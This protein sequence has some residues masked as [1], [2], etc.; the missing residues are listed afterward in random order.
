MTEDTPARPVGAYETFAVNLS[1]AANATIDDAV[2]EGTILND[3]GALPTLSINDIQVVEG[4]AGTTNAV[5]TVTQSAASA[6]TV[7]AGYTTADG[8]AQAAAGTDVY[9]N[10]GTVTIPASG[11][12]GSAGP[13][14]ST[15]T[16]PARTTAV[17]KVTAT[18]SLTHTYPADVDILLV[19]P[20]G[21]SVVLMSDAGGGTDVA[22]VSLTFDDTGPSLGSPLGS[23]TFQPTNS[24]SGDTFPSPAPQTTPGTTLAAFNGL[25]PTGI[26]SLYVQDDAGQDSGSLAT[27]WSLGLEPSVVTGDYVAAAGTVSF[28]PGTTTQSIAVAVVGDT[29]P[30]PRVE[31]VLMR[32]LGS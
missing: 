10:S 15:I 9:A 17:T 32:E 26:W 16:V 12:S 18:L 6:Q 5:F 3:D 31:P 8:T 27:G 11:T 14:P 2:G 23:G 24:G 7:S 13:Y 30:P 1:G 4:N 25:N 20:T 29:D 22:G 19:G 21:E 28:S